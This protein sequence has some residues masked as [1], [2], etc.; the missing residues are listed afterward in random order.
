MGNGRRLAVAL[1]V[2]AILPLLY[3][4][5]F[6][7]ACWISA[8]VDVGGWNGAVPPRAMI[9]Y[10]PLGSIASEPDSLAGRSLR[11]WM[12]LGVKQGYSAS[13]PMSR[14]GNAIIVKSNR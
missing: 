11:W 8:Q 10:W 9:V 12:T 5:P 2:L 3:V 6:G 1:A 13:V 4:L 7:P 14:K